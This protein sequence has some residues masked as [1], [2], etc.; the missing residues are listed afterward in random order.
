MPAAAHV[1]RTQ[2]RA[3]RGIGRRLDRR[4]SDR[5]SAAATLGPAS[6][7]TK[8][9]A[10]NSPRR[11]RRRTE[12]LF[13][14][15]SRRHDRPTRAN[16][17]P[18]AGITLDVVAPVEI[19]GAI[20]SSSRVGDSIAAGNVEEAAKLLGVPY[21]IRG[22]VT[23]GAGRGAKIGFPTA[24]LAAIE[25]LLPAQ[26]V[27]AGRAWAEGKVGR[28]RSMW[29]PARRLATQSSASKST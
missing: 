8:S 1:D 26:G 29:A 2:G 20:V 27:Y 14:P 22:M 16:L 25:T 5:R 4:L 19:D 6:F 11:A 18:R 13:R 12:F 28:Q 17:T 21:R 10:V 3:A 15:Q 7:S 24:N 9:S 23:H